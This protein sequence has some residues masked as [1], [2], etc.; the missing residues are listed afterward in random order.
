MLRT[1]AVVNRQMALLGAVVS[2]SI[3]SCHF[4]THLAYVG[5][6]TVKALGLQNTQFNLGHIMHALSFIGEVEG[7]FP[8]SATAF[9]VLLWSE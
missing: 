6:A 1:C 4:V 8:A 2:L 9:I 5:N 3:P 7:S